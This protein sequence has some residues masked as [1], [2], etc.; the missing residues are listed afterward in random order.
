MSSKFG[1]II[2][3][4]GASER[5]GTPKQLLEVG[6]KPLVARAAEAALAAPV[7]PVVVVLGAHAARIRPALARLPVVTVE[8][9]A[10]AEGMASSIRAG[11]GALQQFSRLIEGGLVG[12]CD[13]PAFS[14]EAIARLIEA[15]LISGLGI[16][17]ARYGGQCG[18]PALFLREH[19]KTLAG[20]SGDE[21]ARALL[22]GDPG[23]I[24]A[25]DMPELAADLDTPAD[26][27]A[28]IGSGG[29]TPS[30]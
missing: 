19:F 16:A 10:W 11:I 24:A 17:A 22:K 5:M 30:N 12:L 29:Q 18:A 14:A 25:V 20:L 4:A 9:P 8:N 23:R 15:Q 7:W 6:G 3:A 21:G 13:Q 27:R 26:Y 28:W 2:L 1:A